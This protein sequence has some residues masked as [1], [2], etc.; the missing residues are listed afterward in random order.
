MTVRAQA[1]ADAINLAP[2]IGVEMAIYRN[3]VLL[4]TVTGCYA[5]RPEVVS[6]YSMEN[7][8]QRA[9]ITLFTPAEADGLLVTDTVVIPNVG[10]RKFY[11]KPKIN[12]FH[13]TTW[14][15]TGA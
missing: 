4:R 1:L 10:E 6:N 12:A 9:S 14:E 5:P 3:G 11:G 13:W 7:T 8:V 15:L 2:E